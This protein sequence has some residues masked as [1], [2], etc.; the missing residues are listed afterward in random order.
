M[1]E[2]LGIAAALLG[3]PDVLLFDEPVNGLDP[4]GIRWVRTLLRS[5][6]SEGRTVLVSSHLMSEMAITADHLLVIGRG[7]L[8]AD[9]SVAEFIAQS[10]QRFVRVRSPR[11]EELATLLAARGAS[12]SG[13]EDASLTVTGLE[14][15]AIGDIA[16]GAGIA[17]H[18]LSP[19]AA[20]L[21]EA[22]M[23]ITHD[24][25]EFHGE[26]ATGA[27]P[28]GHPPAMATAAADEGAR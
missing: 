27:P 19:Q 4:E 15:A 17:L 2:R 23:E 18:E 3:D 10:S 24:S 11:T 12:V 8:I 9:T 28:D 6:A 7:R 14:A 25:V 5:L 26:S 13:A 20:S 1:G 21:E 16:A 22:F